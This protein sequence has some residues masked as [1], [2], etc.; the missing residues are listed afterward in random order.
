MSHHLNEACCLQLHKDVWNDISSTQHT[1]QTVSLQDA[2]QLWQEVEHVV[3]KPETCKNKKWSTIR[4][5]RLD[6]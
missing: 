5:D 6:K 1:L 2:V 4:L 3:Y